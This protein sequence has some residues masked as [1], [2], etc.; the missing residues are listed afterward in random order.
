MYFFV[1]TLEVKA[2]DNVNS[3]HFK[4]LKAFAEE[5]T[6]DKQI[7]VS[8]DPFI[9]QANDMM[10]YPWKVFLEKLWAGEII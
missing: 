4:G 6:V 5:Y 7:I 2:T 1:G 9:R 8:N 3:K 10:I